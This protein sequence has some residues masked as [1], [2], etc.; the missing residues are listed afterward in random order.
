MAQ[1]IVAAAGAA[2]GY[3]TFG[4]GT[5]ALGMS[6][7]QLG[8]MA[9]S[10]LGSAFAPGQKSQGPRLNDLNVGSSQY[11]TPIPYVAG[12][13]RVAGQIVWA[14]S[15][16]EIA[17]TQSAGGKG[18]GGSEYTTYTYEVDLLILLSDNRIAGV[19]R[20]WKNGELV[21]N[22]LSNSDATTVDA[23]INNGG[24]SR[25]TV[26]TGEATQLPDPDYEAAVGTANA[27]AYRGRGTIFIK[28]LQLGGGGQIPNLTF[29]VARNGG[30][31][32]NT[33]YSVDGP[34]TLRT[35]DMA[36]SGSYLYAVG[37]LANSVGIFDTSNGAITQTYSAALTGNPI[38]PIIY[39]G[40]A[41]VL[42]KSFGQ[43]GTY[44][45]SPT[46]FTLVQSMSASDGA[47]TPV[48]QMLIGDTLFIL[49]NFSFSAFSILNPA[50]PV[51]LARVN[52][53]IST[54]NT[55]VYSSLTDTFYTIAG[56]R[57]DSYKYTKPLTPPSYSAFA[58]LK[59]AFQDGFG[60]FSCA[61]ILGSRMYIGTSNS[62]NL[63]IYNIA[64]PSSWFRIGQIATYTNTSALEIRNGLLYV[65]HKNSLSNAFNIYSLENPD[66]P[67]LVETVNLPYTAQSFC[68]NNNEVYFSSYDNY[69]IF[70]FLLSSKKFTLTDDTLKLT[71]DGI[72][73]GT[74]CPSTQYDTTALATITRP[75]RAMAISQV[76]SARTVLEMLAATYH[77]DCVLSDKLYFRPRG[78][79]P[80]ATLTF[81][82]F[83]VSQS[84]E[85]DV[86]PLITANEL[87]TPAQLSLTYNN[88]DGDYQTDTQYSDRLLSGQKSLSTV[89]FPLGFTSTE[90]KQIADAILADKVV[91]SLSTTI[92]V[93]MLKTNLE[94]TDVLL[95]TTED[96]SI[97][98]MRVVKRSETLDVITLDC[99]ADDSTVFTQSGTTSGGTS[100]Q[101]T[102]AALATTTLKLLDLP[103][104]TDTQNKPGLYY[105]VTGSASNWVSSAIYDSLDNVTYLQR[106]SIDTQAPLGSCTTIL[107]SWSNGNIFDETNTVTVNVGLQQLVSVTRDN[108][109][110]NISTN[111]A[112]V[113]NELIQYRTAT[114]IGAGVYTLSGLLRGRRDTSSV[115]HVASEQFVVLS[116]A[117]IGYL[118]LQAGD[119]ARQR[120]YK[121]VSL[122]QA[123]SAVTAQAI[124]PMGNTLKPF[125]PV[126]ARA[127][128]D[129][130][131][132]VITWT[133]QTRLSSRIVGV[134]PA[135]IPLG[136]STENYEIE[137]WNSTYSVLKRTILCSA[138]SATY[139]SAQQFTDFGSNQAIVYVKIYQMSSIVG[140]GSPLTTS[141]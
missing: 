93:S 131:D 57:I 125:A 3:A 108:I 71:V 103:L 1:L 78:S 77:F 58:L 81:D 33:V 136:E 90:G 42:L 65:F 66:V 129:S 60:A 99:V 106:V 104:L 45:I 118:V 64:N 10:L 91:S 70:K 82:E 32:P 87:E 102:V 86:L 123:V 44:S 115:G 100:S 34:S 35:W 88:V 132:T 120:Y 128:R 107:G 11:G 22:I 7:A 89:S 96:S 69:K 135:S 85:Q 75:V 26:Y 72:L 68:F 2:I 25:M 24:W 113:G 40:Y 29:E 74:N 59:G 122:S 53:G 94:P 119:L 110:G 63:H 98:R 38:K 17:T 137:I 43:F 39:G 141:I 84:T 27:P 15:K 114:L 133:R 62:T 52:A 21:Y 41:F 67:A 101:T 130:A 14:S 12:H 112:L 54:E 140:R 138:P 36:S 139:T 8:W 61:A 31:V 92:S 47:V 46:S 56:N 95:L 117:G 6:G 80:V 116:G 30:I 55:L 4:V 73:V 124:V 97:F 105:A 126:N 13:P 18:G 20:I 28:S 83:G 5:V 16:R 19:P 111:A 76:S 79:V 49:S 109:L 127:N 121:G 48:D 37:Y 51:F 134:L 50:V 23:S 9:G